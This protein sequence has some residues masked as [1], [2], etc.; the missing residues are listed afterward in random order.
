M[1]NAMLR[2]AKKT[3]KSKVLYNSGDRNV[4]ASMLPQYPGV[5]LPDPLAQL[6]TVKAVVY[7]ITTNPNTHKETSATRCLFEL[8]TP[9]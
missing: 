5:L 8:A 6:L 9:L 3:K 1:R 2:Y 7:T 4:Q